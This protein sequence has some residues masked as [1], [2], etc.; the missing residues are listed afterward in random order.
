VGHGHGPNSTK[1]HDITT[2]VGARIQVKGVGDRTTASG[3]FNPFR[4]FDF[5][6]AVFLV[7][8]AGAFELVLAREVSSAEAESISGYS[9]HTIGRPDSRA[10]EQ[11][12]GVD[13]TAEMRAGYLALD[14]AHAP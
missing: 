10:S 2:P 3:K 7:L 6:T 11:R 5:D 9:K 14:S 4:S 13:V 1:S 8:A 12:A